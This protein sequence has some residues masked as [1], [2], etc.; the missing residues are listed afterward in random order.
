MLRLFLMVL[1]CLV[2]QNLAYPCPSPLRIQ[3]PVSIFTNPFN[4]DQ[5]I[6]STPYF[7]IALHDYTQPD[8]VRYVFLLLEKKS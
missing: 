5:F 4:V 6:G 8:M 2:D 7:E 1:F 3:D